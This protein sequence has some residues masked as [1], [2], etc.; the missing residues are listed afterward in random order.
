MD[1]TT[2]YFA[3]AMDFRNRADRYRRLAPLYQPDVTAVLMSMA[4]D[5]EA[6][7]DAL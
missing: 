6:A 5:L 4:N 1:N 3:C 7:A 2:F